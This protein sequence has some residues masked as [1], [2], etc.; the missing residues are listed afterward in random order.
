MALSFYT[1]LTLQLL[2][3]KLND[4]LK[5]QSCVESSQTYRS[6]L[7]V[8][9]SNHGS[10][11]LVDRQIERIY[12]IAK[13]ATFTPHLVKHSDSSN[14]NIHEV[15]SWLFSLQDVQGDGSSLVVAS[16]V[17]NTDNFLYLPFHGSL[18]HKTVCL[19]SHKLPD[20]F[21]MIFMEFTEE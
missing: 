12:K 16:N 17:M 20:M 7:P 8:V 11:G 13:H 1:E 21:V 2:C 6:S 9:A 18:S 15:F 5:S 14:R 4:S 19:Y 10:F 3:M